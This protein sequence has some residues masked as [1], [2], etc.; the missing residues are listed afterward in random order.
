MAG[1]ALEILDDSICRGCGQSSLLSYK[2]FAEGEY[3]TRVVTCFACEP[4]EAA[5]ADESRKLGK[6]E[7]RYL[8]DL[9]D[10]PHDE[11]ETGPDQQVR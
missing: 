2:D 4:L 7:K 5:A 9:H 11:P 10:D 8:L 6:G 1:W 3:E